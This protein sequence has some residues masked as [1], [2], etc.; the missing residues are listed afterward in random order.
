LPAVAAPVATHTGWNSRHPDTG[1]P[2]QAAIFV[3]STLFFP[4]DEGDRERSGDVRMSV[5]A[6]YADRAAYLARV[7]SVIDEL[8][9]TGYVLD[10]DRELLLKHCGAHFDWVM[11]GA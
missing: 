1:A 7:A 4:R 8:V 10:E 5:A 2:D 6:R 3:G 11:T 9:T